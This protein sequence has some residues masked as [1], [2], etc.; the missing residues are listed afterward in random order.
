MKLPDIFVPEKSLEGKVKQLLEHEDNNRLKNINVYSCLK[1]LEIEHKPDGEYAYFFNQSLERLKNLGYERHFMPWEIF[2]LIINHLEGK[3]EK[4]LD[5]SVIAMLKNGHEYGYWLNI[6]V[7][8]EEDNLICYTNPKN[9]MKYNQY[10][11][12]RPEGNTLHFDEELRFNV[13][14]IPSEK[15]VELRCFNEDFVEFFYSREF[16]DLPKIIQEGKVYL[17]AENVLSP[18]TLWLPTN[19]R[20][21][22]FNLSLY[23]L[24]ALSRGVRI[25]K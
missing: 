24:D 25:R 8:K 13:K 23:E 6:A 14:G 18:G 22:E 19:S 17:P 5:R 12:Y 1:I 21:Q 10:P 3:L 9:L 20:G 16:K 2:G 4:S 15:W 11:D 7:S